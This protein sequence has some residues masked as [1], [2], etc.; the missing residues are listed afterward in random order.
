[1][2]WGIHRDLHVF[3]KHCFVCLGRDFKDELDFDRHAEG[4]AG[5]AEDDATRK[6]PAAE[7]LDEELGRSVGDFGMVPEIAFRR[8][9]DTEFRHTCYL[10]E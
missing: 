5:D 1:M 10:V 3:A 7:D 9:I 2:G 8:D 4:Q 6:H